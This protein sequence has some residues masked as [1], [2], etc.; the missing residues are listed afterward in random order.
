MLVVRPI[1]NMVGL[2]QGRKPQHSAIR[3]CVF[4]SSSS[5]VLNHWTL[6]DGVLSAGP[7]Q[8]RGGVVETGGQEKGGRLSCQHALLG[9]RRVLGVRPISTVSAVFGWVAAFFT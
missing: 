1:T 8:L 2:R 6:P 3:A 4:L 9:P 7:G 5:S